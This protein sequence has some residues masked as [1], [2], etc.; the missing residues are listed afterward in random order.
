MAIR[1]L[2]ERR[3]PHRRL[4]RH[5][6]FDE[7]SRNFRVAP[8]SPTIA[9]RLWDRTVPAFDQGELGSCTGQGAA[10]LL[11]TEPFRVGGW[12]Y[13]EKLSV[14]LYANATEDDEIEGSYPPHDTG[15]TVL[16]AMRATTR[17]G[18]ASSYQ[19][20]FGLE[21]TLRTLSQV[22]PI[23][24]GVNWYEGFDAPDAQGRIHFGGAVRGGHAFEVL[25]VDAD[26]RLVMAINSWGSEWGHE[27]R[28]AIS[29]DD[30]DRL[31]YEDGEAATIAI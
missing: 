2:P 17:L 12:T 31:L 14:F 10:G 6:D 30:L 20:C 11:C 24:V 29:W 16:A 3:V 25:G 22:G 15:S 18:Y 27:G 19:W 5:V 1:L 7:R 4:G 28:F 13:T 9:T 21:D 8:P 26:T 23:E